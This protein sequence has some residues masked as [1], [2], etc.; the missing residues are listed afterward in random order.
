M[1]ISE[2]TT[3]QPS[4]NVIGPS[5]VMDL[6]WC[7]LSC[8]RHQQTHLNLEPF[9]SDLAQYQS[10]IEGF[11]D[12]GMSG[13]AE[14][15]MLAS[16]AG[17][18][19]VTDFAVLRQKCD[20]AL[21]SQNLDLKLMSETAHDEPLILA[22]LRKLRDSAALRQRYFDL[23]SEVWSIVAPWWESEGILSIRRATAQV[24][25]K[26]AKGSRWYDIMN[27]ECAVFEDRLPE[28]IDHYENGKPV[29]LLACAFFGKGLYIEFPDSIL[30][31]F[32]AESTVEEAKTRVSSIVGPLRALADPTRLAIF[33]FLKSGPVTIMDIAESFS[34]SQPTISVHVK[35]LRDV[36]LVKATRQGNQ[37][38]ITI[39]QVQADE[40][41]SAF[42]EIVSR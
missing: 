38:E 29:T 9:F 23:L 25:R 27:T 31:G 39:N 17:A 19:E 21:R 2:R 14:T 34:L 13:L 24:Q 16:I 22:R 7:L 32:G 42:A 18:L 6:S 4:V 1:Q 11:W 12:D 33:E 30:I 37:L 10:R 36:G 5:L 3:I 28:I 35:R 41:T 26:L 40:L 20:E 8:Q 15:Q